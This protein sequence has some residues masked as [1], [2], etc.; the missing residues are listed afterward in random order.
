MMIETK[1]G[2]SRFKKTRI[3]LQW[4]GF[5]GLVV[6]LVV[7]W[8]LLEP[9]ITK[10]RVL[11]WDTV[12]KTT[13]NNANFLI[14]CISSPCGEK[15]AGVA[16]EILQAKI[17][18]IAMLG[19]SVAF[20]LFGFQLSIIER[21]RFG[22][23]PPASGSWAQPHELEP[24][25]K[26]QEEPSG[27]LGISETGQVLRPSRKLRV[28]H[29]SALGGQGSGKTTGVIKPNLW[30][31]AMGGEGVVLF[32]IKFPDP[33]SGFFD[34]L[35]WFKDY[36]IQIFTPYRAETMRLP[37]LQDTNTIE[38]AM[39]M[40]E[41][42]VGKTDN[43]AL[44]YYQSNSKLLLANLILAETNFGAGSL[45]NILKIFTGGL[46]AVEGRILQLT[47]NDRV[48]G[49]QI[50][51]E[52]SKQKR[53]EIINGLVQVLKPWA[54]EM[55]NKATTFS[56]VPGENVDLNKLGTSKSILYIGIQQQFLQGESG[57]LLQGLL[58]RLISRAVRDN[59]NKYADVT[60]E[61]PVR[62][63]IYL[64]EFANLGYLH[65]FEEDITTM[66]SFNVS[67]ILGMQNF[68]QGR[69]RYTPN[70][71]GAI[72]TGIATKIYFPSKIKEGDRKEVSDALGQITVEEETKS[73]GVS[74]STTSNALSRNR[75]ITRRTVALVAPEEFDN[76]AIQ[77]VIIKTDGIRPI[78]CYLPRLDQAKID[79]KN[80][81]N[82]LHQAWKKQTVR[83]SKE[84][85]TSFI[86]AQIKKRREEARIALLE[87]IQKE[88]EFLILDRAR[89]ADAGER[90]GA[91]ELQSVIVE[92]RTTDAVASSTEA[93]TG[94]RPRGR[95]K[96]EK[97]VMISQKTVTN[98]LET[99]ELNTARPEQ[100]MAAQRQT[101]A[102][103]QEAI[104]PGTTVLT[105]PR[106]KGA[107]LMSDLPPLDYGSIETHQVSGQQ[108]KQ[109]PIPD[110]NSSHG[111]AIPEKSQTKPVDPQAIS[112]KTKDIKVL[113]AEKTPEKP[114]PQ[115][116]AKTL[117]QEEILNQFVDRILSR[118]AVI[119]QK[120]DGGY[121]IDRSTIGVKIK[122]TAE[123]ESDF[124]KVSE[125][126]IEITSVGMQKVKLKTARKIHKL[127]DIGEIVVYVRE[128]KLKGND[129]GEYEIPEEI[130]NQKNWKSKLFEGSKISLKGF[131]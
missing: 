75:T 19:G 77:E 52:L 26:H 60:G 20:L 10:M 61:L 121:G 68:S 87:K 69:L 80:I 9:I 101:Q 47:I 98:G 15:F 125:K 79:K 106:F 124:L 93:H 58:Y 45:G 128:N 23:K 86:S 49:F 99:V 95:K 103:I 35:P 32:D 14:R 31:D 48:P 55:L 28:L 100:V 113:T 84:F 57:E 109:K 17:Y 21:T 33:R 16:G 74:R 3:L 119:G 127:C 71:F 76:F 67:I 105:D 90:V 13:G 30:F 64:D 46:N 18:P 70:G 111:E 44:E 27:Y 42:I 38:R 36:D 96:V 1:L 102:P 123:L 24:L 25:L 104:I 7:I 110:K 120:E 40:A 50:F 43:A 97:V 6:S 78:R 62:L 89:K 126:E 41:F 63:N 73:I 66:R 5:I 54:N 94:E 131:L 11:G 8:W 53:G 107:S 116:E 115:T 72:Y 117:S 91:L 65:R 59:A 34:C 114:E 51:M 83:V 12:L 2:S 122:S 112:P 82:P 85:V 56:P 129:K 92:R 81:K 88:T 22:K 108:E 29:S 130:R 118:G 37:L 4:V 39:E